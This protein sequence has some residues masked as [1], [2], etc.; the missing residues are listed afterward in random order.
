MAKTTAERQAAYRATR[1]QAGINGDG[2]KRLSLW[3]GSRGY[4]A[5]GRL[6]RHFGVT[7]RDLIERL[8]RAEDERLIATLQLDTPEWERYFS[9][10]RWSINPPARR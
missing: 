1:A 7:K 4:F 2:E 6:A 9:C 3:I 10:H 8:V 5:L